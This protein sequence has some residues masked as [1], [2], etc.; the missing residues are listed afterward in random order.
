MKNYIQNKWKKFK[1]TLTVAL[2]SKTKKEDEEI[3]DDYLDDSLLESPSES[4]STVLLSSTH[5]DTQLNFRSIS[6]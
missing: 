5:R 1:T 6:K 2:K 3:D 4:D